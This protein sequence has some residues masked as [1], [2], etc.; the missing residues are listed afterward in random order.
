MASK[1]REINMIEGPFLKKIIL[2]IIPLILTG[3]LQCFYN[4]ADLAVVGRFDGELALAAVG[5]TGSLN[6]LIVSLFMGLSVGA[7]VVV[8]H[9]MGALKY[10][11]VNKVVH[12]AVLMASVLGVIVSVIGIAFTRPLLQWMDTPA[13]VLD[14]AVIYTRIVFG[15]IPAS[16]VYNY[17]ASMVRSTGD[18]K[19]PLIFL[20]I[21]G[22]VNVA[23][24]LVLV[25]CFHLGV[26]GVA[27]GTIASQYL[28]AVMILFFTSDQ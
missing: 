5:S 21:S 15:G 20:S 3:L 8:A 24:N 14:Q 7:G 12:S 27:I 17:C 13:N 16:M 4:A 19:H 26:V 23:L 18:T 2:F 22:L 6:N 28:S 9:Q 25:I 1:H 11:R 10:K